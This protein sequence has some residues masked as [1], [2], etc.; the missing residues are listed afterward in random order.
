MKLS[1]EE[2]E[3]KAKQLKQEYMREYRKNHKEENKQYMKTYWEK[4]ALSTITAE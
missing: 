2:L 1:Q 4:K 3:L